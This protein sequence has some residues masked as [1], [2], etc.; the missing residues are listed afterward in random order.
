MLNNMTFAMLTI[1]CKT[2][3]SNWITVA[4][5]EKPASNKM[6]VFGYYSEDNIELMMQGNSL[7]CAGGKT[8]VYNI[9]FIFECKT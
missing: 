4:E 5:F 3:Y 7:K 6:I 2:P 9:T 1:T 8:G